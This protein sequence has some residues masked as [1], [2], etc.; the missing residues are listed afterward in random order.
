[1]DSSYRAHLLQHSPV[2]VIQEN[3]QFPDKRDFEKRF[4]A[5]H[6]LVMGDIVEVT[7]CEA[8]C[9]H[10]EYRWNA[11]PSDLKVTSEL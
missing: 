11:E 9:V 8:P 5:L 2:Q 1:M 7:D 6:T 10:T 4:H 3:Y